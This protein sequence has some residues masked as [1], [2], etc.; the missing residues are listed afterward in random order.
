MEQRVLLMVNPMAGRQKIRNELFIQHRV[1]MQQEICWLR[2]IVSLTELF[3]AAEMAPLMRFCRQRCIGI[4]A[5][6]W[7]IFLQEPP[8]ILQQV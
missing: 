2:R 6:F 8:M 4:S 7:G 1:R 3:A 5:L